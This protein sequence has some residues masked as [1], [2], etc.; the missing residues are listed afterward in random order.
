MAM[1]PPYVDAVCPEGRLHPAGTGRVDHAGHFGWE[2]SY[3]V[4]EVFTSLV[5]AASW[6]WLSVGKWLS[7]CM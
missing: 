1:C 5:A 6:R 7:C 4:V 3:Q 2:S